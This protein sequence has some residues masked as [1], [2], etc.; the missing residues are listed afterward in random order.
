MKRI[1]SQVSRPSEVERK[2]S[3]EDAEGGT[4]SRTR[5]ISQSSPDYVWTLYSKRWWICAAFFGL[6][7]T[8]TVSTICLSAFLTD[9]E[10]PYAFDI[11]SYE[12]SLANSASAIIFFPSFILTTKLY[13]VTELRNVLLI[14]SGMLF[15]GSWLRMVVYFNKQFWW[16]IAGQAI[17]GSSSPMTTC[18]VSIIAN[19]WFGDAE[20]GRATAFM[21]VSNPLGILVSFGIQAVYSEVIKR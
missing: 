7:F 1:G 8:Q 13:N 5:T 20:R 4:G 16:V 6:N 9:M 10:S 15:V 17:I 21:L 14:C 18:A 11:T 3:D 19:L 12:V 2:Q